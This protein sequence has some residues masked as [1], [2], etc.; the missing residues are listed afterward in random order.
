MIILATSLI[1]QCGMFRQPS[2]CYQQSFGWLILFQGNIETS[3]SNSAVFVSL[4]THGSYRKPHEAI[5]SL[6][7]IDQQYQAL[8]PQLMISPHFL[9]ENDEPWRWPEAS[10]RPQASPMRVQCLGILW[11]EVSSSSWGYP[12]GSLDGSYGKADENG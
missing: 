2:P 12:S 10:Q 1:P 11:M 9:M 7:S 6:S 8:D 4:L 3:A 5:V